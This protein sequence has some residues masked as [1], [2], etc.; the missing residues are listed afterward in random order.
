MSVHHERPVLSVAPSRV[1]TQDPCALVPELTRLTVLIGQLGPALEEIAHLLADRPT[2]TAHL[3]QG[4]VSLADAKRA[5]DHAIGTLDFNADC[6]PGRAA[7]RWSE[8]S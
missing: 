2:V 8:A 5:V 4:R 7:L 1:N 6:A 3:Q